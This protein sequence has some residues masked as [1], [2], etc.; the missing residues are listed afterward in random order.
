MEEE[1]DLS[2][3]ID[4]LLR[5]WWLILLGGLLAG[6]SA[7]IVSMI[8]TPSY[9]ATASVVTL[10][11]RAEL[12]LGSGFESLTE[13]D[14]ALQQGESTAQR[15]ALRL[16]SL[17]NMVS[18]GAIALQVSE[19]LSDL[20]TE[21]DEGDPSRLLAMVEGEVVEDSDTIRII[22]SH[23]DPV[24]AAAIANTWA[25]SFESRVNAIYG[26]APFTPFAD[27]HQQVEKAQVE[28]DQ[29]QEEW[30]RFLAEQD[31]ISELQRQVAEQEELLVRLRTGR[32]DSVTE[33]VN[34]QV[35]VQKR[36]FDISVGSEI[37]FTLMVFEKR[38]NELVSEYTDAYA[39]K[40]RFESLLYEAN[41]IR[42]QLVN[43]EA[44][45]ANTSGLALWNFKQK[46]LSTGGVP[47]ERL[48][49]QAVS[50][51]DA[52]TINRSIEEQLADLDA[53]IDMMEA[54]V[55]AQEAIIQEYEAALAQNE[56][57][58]FLES[59]TPEYLDMANSQSELALQ[60]TV[61]WKGLL[62]YSDLLEA[63]FSGEIAQL[64]EDVRALKAEII[65]LNGIKEEMQTARDLAWK[66][67]NNLLSKEQELQ[68]STAS[69]G[70][71]VRFASPALPPRDPVSPRKMLN[72]AVGLALG[73]ML[74]MFGA[75]LFD[76]IG[77]ESD[78]RRLL[79][80]RAA[81][82]GGG[83]HT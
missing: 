83:D 40:W 36:I 32:Q 35:G 7:L 28:Y 55:E 29:A 21:E 46:V 30:V 44:T 4:V 77:V 23:S 37:N 75:F 66:A 19:E 11:S 52:L 80:Q 45:S 76:Y 79:G 27:I 74:G 69:E 26:D 9:E 17:A 50:L 22:V 20:W 6:G 24:K 42:E 47:I 70:T 63:P 73:L 39:R 58:Q 31:R 53:L 41:L 14:M 8:M 64:E 13:E 51:E 65:R 38:L 54:E 49:L 15:N 1:I 61:D 18:N 10:K 3:Y 81:A 43:G 16:N 72:A 56:S 60:R 71:E 68:I 82:D 62:G 2:Q 78:P 57:Y 5:W 33:I 48:E 25:Q 67:Y 12:S 34:R 59:L